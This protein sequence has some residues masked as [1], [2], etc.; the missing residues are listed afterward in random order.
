VTGEHGASPVPVP[1]QRTVDVPRA[2]RAAAPALDRLADLARRLL[3]TTQAEVRLGT[4][5][6]AATPAEDGDAVPDGMCSLVT[7]E[8]PLVVP[9]ASA[10]VRFQAVP[11]VADGRL[12]AFLGV[13]LVGERGRRPRRP[14]R[15]GRQPARLDRT[16]T[17]RR[18][19]SWPAPVVAELELAALSGRVP[20]HARPLG[21]RD[22]RGRRRQ[23]RLGPHERR[24]ALGRPAC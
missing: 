20:G 23:L 17:S 18:S 11:A 8:G 24:A 2:S 3:G 12:A 1:V 9:D 16:P 13:P 6:T 10:D 21:A 7:G 15:L 22:R 19:G 4:A 14:V 5:G